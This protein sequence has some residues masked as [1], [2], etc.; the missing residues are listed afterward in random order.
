M[1]FFTLLKM[2]WTYCCFLIHTIK[3][4]EKSVVTKCGDKSCGDKFVVTNNV[5]IR[6]LNTINAFSRIVVAIP[7]SLLSIIVIR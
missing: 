6:T 5:L 4:M 7:H 1:V 3:V 2:C